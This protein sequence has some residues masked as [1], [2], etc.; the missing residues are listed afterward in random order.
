MLKGTP[1]GAFQKPTKR[2]IPA[3]WQCRDRDYRYTESD[4]EIAASQLGVDADKYPDL[5][6]GMQHELEHHDLTCGSILASAL[7]SLAH[8]REDEDYYK[9]LEA[10]GLS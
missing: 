5:L 2:I 10:C 7:I 1:P 4:A 6:R 8:F 9:K 3:L